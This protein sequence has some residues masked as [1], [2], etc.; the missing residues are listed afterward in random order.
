MN[1]GLLT[2]ASNPPCSPSK[3][4]RELKLPNGSIAAASNAPDIPCQ[5]FLSLDA[6]AADFLYGSFQPICD[7]DRHSHNCWSSALPL[8]SWLTMAV[9]ISKSPTIPTVREIRF[10]CESNCAIART[11][12]ISRMRTARRR[13]RSSSASVDCCT[14]MMPRVE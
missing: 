8:T 12:S 10:A 11:S 7:V 1:G 4:L 3:Y 5:A 13:L 14:N 6:E 2:I 9:P